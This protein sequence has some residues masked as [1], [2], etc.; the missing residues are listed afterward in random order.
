MPYYIKERKLWMAQVIHLKKTYRKGFSTK[1][2]AKK[3]EAQKKEILRKTHI[4][5]TPT[6]SLIEF[7]IRYL[8]YSRMKHSRKT[9]LEKRLAFKFLLKSLPVDTAIDSIHK[10]DVLEHLKKQYET[11]SGNSANKDRKNL[12]AA[13]NW[14]F[15]YL[16]GV[17]KDNPFDIQR[18]PEARQPRYIPPKEDFWKVVAVAETDQDR[19]MLYSYLHLAARKRELF[20]LKWDDIDFQEK[21]VR[22]YTRKRKDG[23][24]EFDWLPLT[25]F[26]YEQFLIFKRKVENGQEYVFPNPQNGTAY[27]E[28]S[29]WMNRLCE[30]A[31]VKP[32]GLHAIRHLSASILMENDVPLIDIKT[33]LRH[34]NLATTER[35]IHRLRSVRESICVFDKQSEK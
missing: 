20:V 9:Y 29:R 6:I 23:S 10:G 8:D 32:F 2:E 17:P 18:F 33:I 28:K 16:K 26:L 24:Q 30:A 3:W 1:Q 11:R 12:V 15:H 34:K 22:L 19:L 4:L 7:S 14:A 35:Y 31:E 5:K 25:N 21:K 27:T 13:W